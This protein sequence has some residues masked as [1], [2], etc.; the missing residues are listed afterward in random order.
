MRFGRVK[1]WA[2]CITFYG[3]LRALPIFWHGGGTP[4][5]IAEP[6]DSNAVSHNMFSTRL[7]LAQETNQVSAA[8]VYLPSVLNFPLS[9]SYPCRDGHVP[10]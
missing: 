8:L 5:T 1:R 9:M 2:D 6:D 10:I 4:E 3:T 7:C